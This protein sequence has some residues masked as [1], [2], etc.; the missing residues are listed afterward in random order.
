[1]RVQDRLTE[2]EIEISRTD[3]ELQLMCE[4]FGILRGD[5]ESTFAASTQRHGEEL[6][7]LQVRLVS[8]RDALADW[9]AMQQ[10]ASA[11]VAAQLANAD[12]TTEASEAQEAQVCARAKKAIRELKVRLESEQQA[13][14]HAEDQVNALRKEVDQLW[15]KLRDEESKA[16]I[17]AARGGA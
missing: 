2:S 11:R 13:R 17:I 10:R 12:V 3:A 15:Q 16:A 8:L 1:M 7:G 5:S 4:H 14:S 6:E 9:V